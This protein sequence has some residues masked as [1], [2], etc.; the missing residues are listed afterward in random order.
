M[1]HLSVY[2]SNGF[3]SL[4]HKLDVFLIR[5]T[6]L[7]MFFAKAN[8]YNIVIAFFFGQNV[9]VYISHPR[10]KG[11]CAQGHWANVFCIF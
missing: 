6:H 8:K 10:G 1:Y 3:F 9:Q 2:Q 7:C 11:V 4:R 5:T